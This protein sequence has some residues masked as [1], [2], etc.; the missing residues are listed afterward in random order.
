M[1]GAKI[2]RGT[3]SYGRNFRKS[4]TGRM[5]FC[6]SSEYTIR[7]ENILSFALV[8]PKRFNFE[9]RARREIAAVSA[10]SCVSRSKLRI[11]FIE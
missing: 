11:P 6:N 3:P 5:L 8:C 7:A 2:V 9:K 1:G 4:M 10:M